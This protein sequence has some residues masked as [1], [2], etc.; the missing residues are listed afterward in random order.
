[1]RFDFER[2]APENA[3]GL[4]FSGGSRG[5][6]P[7]ENSALGP[8]SNGIPEALMIKRHGGERPSDRSAFQR[9]RGS[10]TRLRELVEGSCCRCVQ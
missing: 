7:R 8:S 10:E 4:Y 3:M 9:R 6:H 1:M 5:N 2:G